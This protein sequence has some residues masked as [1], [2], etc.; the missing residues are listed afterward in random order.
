MN[1]WTQFVSLFE[2]GLAILADQFGF[3]GD[4]RWA[5]AIVVFTLASRAIL[6]PLSTKQIRS[7]QAMQRLKPEMDRL[8]KKLKG[9]K[10]KLVKA[11]QEL[12]KRE[13][14]HPLGC[15][16]PMVL[17]MPI[18]FAM[19]RAMFNLA[20][21]GHTMP[22]LGL[23]DLSQS[24]RAS[25]AGI[26][27]LAIMT[28]TSIISTK[29]LS[30]AQNAQQQKTM[31]LMP[32]FFVVIMINFPAGVVLYWATNNAFQFVQQMIMLKKAPSNGDVQDAAKEVQEDA[33]KSSRNGA[34]DKELKPFKAS[35]TSSAFQPRGSGNR[36]GG[37]GANTNGPGRKNKNA[38]RKAR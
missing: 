26:V 5:A 11:Q 16:G 33:R 28:I 12:W 3:L 2:R 7:T 13:G 38:K 27:L 15:M 18:L 37:R 21:A 8:Q 36:A 29:Q 35:A 4:H 17:Q 34:S 6:L 23:G 25:A 10:E 30:T 19:Y 20:K 1:I 9:D 24:A 31:M 14:V 22:F 32:I